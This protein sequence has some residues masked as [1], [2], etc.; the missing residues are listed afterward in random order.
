MGNTEL[1]D[2]GFLGAN[3]TVED[4]AFGSSYVILQWLNG[5]PKAKKSGGIPYTGGFFMSGDQGVEPPPGF[6]EYT[7]VTDDAVEVKGFA[8]PTLTGSVIRYRRCW[9]SEPEENSGKRNERFGWDEYEE[10]QAHG[11]P[12]GV[13]HLLFG[14]KSYDEPVMLVFRGMV[15][16]SVMGQGRQRGIVPQFAQQIVS[17]AKR[18]A[19]KNKQGSK[20]FPLCAFVLTMGGKLESDGKTPV[21]DVVGQGN[22]TSQVTYPIWRDAPDAIVDTALLNR[23]YVGNETFATYQDYHTEASDW[24]TAW[25]SDELAIRNKREV[26]ATG[27]ALPAADGAGGA[28]GEQEVGF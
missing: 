2:T 28:P 1:M 27:A 19:R 5:S 20:S 4:S 11:S 23:L 26:K 15:A 8:S 24:V 17:A 21:F 25:N 22:K 14:I 12:R 6:E 16:K 9:D 7:L 10:A 18:I 3:V 13:C